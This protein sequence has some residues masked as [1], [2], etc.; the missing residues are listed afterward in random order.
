MILGIVRHVLTGA[1]S[2]L[3]TKGLADSGTVE[4]GVGAV[5]TLAGLIWSVVHKKG[6]ENKIEAAKQG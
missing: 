3:V 6:V 5:I 2:I 1:G 4:A